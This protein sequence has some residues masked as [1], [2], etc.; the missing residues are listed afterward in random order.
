MVA[1]PALL[2]GNVRGGVGRPDVLGAGTDEAVVVQLLD[3]VGSPAG[4][5]ADGEDGRVEVDVDAQSRV[6]R[7]RVKVHVGVELLVGVDVELD[8][9]GVIEPLGYAGR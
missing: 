7:G 9:A 1:L 6:R 5:A 4:D 8:G 3:D 2:H